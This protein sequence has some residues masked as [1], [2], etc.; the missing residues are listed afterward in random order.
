MNLIKRFNGVL[1]TDEILLIRHRL[2]PI[3][4]QRDDTF[5]RTKAR[6]PQVPGF[7]TAKLSR[8]VAE[9]N[10][11]FEFDI[12]TPVQF[13]SFT[14]GCYGTGE[15]CAVHNDIPTIHFFTP[16][17]RKLSVVIGVNDGSEYTGGDFVFSAT[18]DLNGLNLDAIT[19]IDRIRLGAGDV[20]IYPGF[21]YHT[22]EPVTSG[23]RESLTT[24]VMGPRFR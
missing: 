20:V 9:A 10:K 11:H 21:V 23:F 6:M 1:S 16:E 5:T 4:A 15:S 7:V 22:V 17:T 2:D 14:Y 12:F 13:E 8:I 3:V 24:M 19:E 18:T